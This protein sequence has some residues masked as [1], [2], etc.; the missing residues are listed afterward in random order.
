MP[1]SPPADVFILSAFD[2]DQWCPVLQTRFHVDHLEAL[3]S[4]L[5]EQA[6]DDLEL[7]HQYLLDDDELRAVIGRFAVLFDPTRLPSK[8]PDIFLFR[9]QRISEA[10][11]LIHTG[12]ELPLLLDGRKKLARMSHEYPPNTFE[13]EARFDHWV[14][15]GVL[16]KTEVSEPCDKPI[17]GWLGHRT[18]YYTPVG[19][20]WRVP[21]VQLLSKA[22]GKS[23]GWNEHFERLAGMLFGYSDTE[24]DWW[25]NVGLHGGGF[26]GAGICCAVGLE[27]LAWIEAAGFRAL[28]PSNK[29][30]V[31]MRAYWSDSENELRD[32]FFEDPSAVA[33]IR[34]NVLGRHMMNIV[35]LRTAGPWDVPSDQI[36]I[37]NQHLR[38]SVVVVARRVLPAGSSEAR[39]P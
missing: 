7:R 12:Y 16:S 32:L 22:S 36:P 11:Y 34:F 3:R 8:R 13:G 39:A 15:G 24:N 14:S 30:T 18:I 17:K 5:G 37:I 9:K 21:A 26:G 25:V 31:K 33:F 10:P 35:D 23:G 2:R 28:P 1:S 4:I 38:G 19:E 29:P 6:T 27:S 20:E